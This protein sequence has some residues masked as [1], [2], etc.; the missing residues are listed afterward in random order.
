MAK[1]LIPRYPDFAP[2]ELGHKEEIQ[3]YLSKEQPEVSELSFGSIYCWRKY[4]AP[5]VSRMGSILILR[6]TMPDHTTRYA[7][8]IG[9]GNKVMAVRRLFADGC[10]CMAGVTEPLLSALRDAG[11]S[12]EP[13]R[14]NWDY[15]YRVEDLALLSGTRYHRRR[16]DI[17]R[18]EEST[19]AAYRPMSEEHIEECIGLAEDW[20]R[21]MDCE[22]HETLIFE[23]D[24]ILCAL[25]D[26]ST[27]GLFGGVVFADRE[28]C[29]FTIAEHLRDGMAVVHFEKA[30]PSL[31]GAYQHINREFAAQALACCEWVNREQDLGLQGLRKNKMSYHPHHMV[32]KHVISA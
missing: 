2:V 21:H 24:A 3:L 22:E 31:P 26:F 4:Y 20:C 32:E 1:P 16:K 13:D 10:T 11:F 12:A 17:R 19:R 29:A 28:I 7:P 8:P 23:K 5:F 15:V 25:E 30:D 27:L 6:V 18:F 9:E 14:D